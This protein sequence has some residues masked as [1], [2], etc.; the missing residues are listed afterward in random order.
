MTDVRMVE[1]RFWYWVECGSKWTLKSFVDLGSSC[2]F[3]LAINEYSIRHNLGPAVHLQWKPSLSNGIFVVCFRICSPVKV[4][5]TIGMDMF[6]LYLEGSGRPVGNL[7]KVHFLYFQILPK[8][9]GWRLFVPWLSLTFCGP[10]I[11]STVSGSFW[12][13]K[14]IIIK[15]CPWWRLSEWGARENI[16]SV[17]EFLIFK[18]LFSTKCLTKQK[19]QFS[20]ALF[21]L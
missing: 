13:T 6:A 20:K 4:R 15:R 5:V 21:L 7:H 9:K 3:S 17:P 19:S 11:H 18:T 12:D 14:D 8:N 1:P 10:G 2:D 16:S